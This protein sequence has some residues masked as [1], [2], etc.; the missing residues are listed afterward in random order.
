MTATM[1]KITASPLPMDALLKRYTRPAWEQAVEPYT[2]CFSA[3]FGRSIGLEQFVDAFYT[4]RLF[5]LERTVL[6]WLAGKPSSDDQARRVACGD[7]D[8]FAAWRVEARTDKQLLM[9]DFRNRTRSWF[10]VAPADEETGG[11]GV[12]LFFGSAVVPVRNRKTGRFQLGLG[13]TLLLGFHKLYSRALL[14]AAGAR[15]RRRQD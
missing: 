8:S 12:R 2:D 11:D 15:L 14:N 9:C 7:A 3:T 5:K 4:T 10:M 1:S 6:D 13:F